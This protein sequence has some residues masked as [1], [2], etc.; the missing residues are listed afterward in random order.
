MGDGADTEPTPPRD[1]AGHREGPDRPW[2]DRYA[3]APARY[4]QP[5]R[6]RAQLGPGLPKC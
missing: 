1:P 6:L 4:R 5:M 3:T 2:F